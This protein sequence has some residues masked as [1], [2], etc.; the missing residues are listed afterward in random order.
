MTDLSNFALEYA[1]PDDDLKE[2]VSSFYLFRAEAAEIDQTE[3]ADRAQFRFMLEGSG[4]YTFCD[5]VELPAP[6]ITI[7]GP[8]TG[9]TVAHA[10]GPVE[11]FGAGLQPAGWGALMGS[12]GARYTNRL[13]D[14]TAVFGDGLLAVRDALIAA[15][16]LEEKVAVGSHLARTLLQRAESPPF[17]FTRT[18][19]AWLTASASPR[20]DDLV[21]ATGL[22]VRQVERMTKRFY[23]ASP[24]LLARKYRALRAASALMRNAGD[25][26]DVGDGFYDQSHLIRELKWFTGITPG[27]MREAPPALARAV[28]ERRNLLAGKVGPLITDT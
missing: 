19:D 16:S 18:V 8:T 10:R 5:G 25:G 2:L 26:A 15:K 28:A 24:K 4:S 13:L 1:A 9:V 11:I 14:A 12:G 23:G 3:R 27:Q 20:I 21:S 17:W 22:S 6:A 7:L